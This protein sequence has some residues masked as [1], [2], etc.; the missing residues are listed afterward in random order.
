[1]TPEYLLRLWAAWDEHPGRK[2]RAD[3][4]EDAC[5]AYEPGFVTFLRVE[6]A[7]ARRAGLS[8]E[9]ALRQWEALRA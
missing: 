5:Q 4:F 3:A 8:R 7:R 2:D 6:L 1:M 9:D